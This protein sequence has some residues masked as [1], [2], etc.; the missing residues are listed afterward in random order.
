MKIL[1]KNILVDAS[2]VRITR[3][4]VDSPDIAAAAQPGQFILLMVSEEGERIPLTIV[5]ADKGRGA[6]TLIVQELG[7][8]TRLLGRR[9]AGDSLYSLAGPLGRPTEVRRYGKIAVV[10]G[11]VGIAEIWPVARVLKA[12]GNEVTSILGAR[13]KGLM[14][15]EKE[16]AACSDRTFLCTDDGTLGEKG[17]VSNVLSKLLE[18]ERFDLVYC[19][20]PLPMMRV[21][22]DV[23]R[24]FGVKTLV[25]LN[26][27][28]LDGTGM[29]GGCRLTEGGETK[30]C[31]VDGPEFDGHRVD[32]NE[33][34]Q[35]QK[36]FV[37]EEKRAMEKPAT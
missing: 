11:G 7:Y 2:G 30:F 21:V 15:L 28:M 6:I 20:G 23:T 5:D 19:V 3:L 26:T 4:D 32:F 14:I 31:C 16:M 10:G 36:R 13:S 8:T 24:P 12:A 33:L 35:R 34:L 9:Q 27:I 17:F 22:S 37:S 18:K 29:C 1:S 25:C